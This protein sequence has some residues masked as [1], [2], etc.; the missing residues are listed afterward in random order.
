MLL[1]ELLVGALPFDCKMLRQAGYAEIQRLIREAEPLKPSTRLS[2][3][4]KAAEEAARQRQSDVRR[5][6][7]LLRGDLETIVMKALEKDRARRYASA[8]E[9]AADIGRHLAH[10]P[11]TARPPALAYQVGRFLKRQRSALYWCGA[12]ILLAALTAL[13]F[14]WRTPE[15]MPQILAATQLTGDGAQKYGLVADASRLYFTE[16]IRKIVQVPVTGG[17]VA[18]VTSLPNP[19]PVAITPDSSALLVAAGT[20]GPSSACFLCFQ[21]WLVPVSSGEPHKLANL[22]SNDGTFFPDGR[23]ILYGSTQGIALANRD[24]ENSRLLVRVDGPVRSPRVSPDQRRIRFFQWETHTDSI[25]LWESDVAGRHLHRL[26]TDWPGLSNMGHSSGSGNWTADGRYFVFGA[27]HDGRVDLWA[28]PEKTGFF[29]RRHSEPIRLTNGPMSYTASLPSS[30]GTKIFALATVGR[31]ELVR[32]D[33]SA[34]EFVPFLSGVSADEIVF[35]RDG[36]WAVYTTYPD[37]SLWRSRLDGSERLRLTYPPLE[38][39]RPQVSPEGSHV[40]FYS[41]KP[42]ADVYVVGMQGGT[43]HLVQR[44]AFSPV[45]SP[46]GNR[47]AVAAP[48]K[49][50]FATRVL[51]LKTGSVTAVSD[52]QLKMPVNWSPGNRLV[53]VNLAHTKVLA[54]DFQTQKWSPL[55]SVDISERNM[56]DGAASVDGRYVYIETN[57]KPSPKVIRI[58]VSD[59]HIEPVMQIGKIR[60]VVDPSQGTTLGV[61]PDGSVLV[62]HDV[63]RSRGVFLESEVAVITAHGRPLDCFD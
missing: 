6:V 42:T 41:V 38:A 58:R 7:R 28:L 31:G 19:L 54:F 10:E 22:E 55:L 9:F 57:E 26:L 32:F 59:G 46:D 14:W 39:Y 18:L 24:G 16:D 33:S 52:G 4:G 62:T 35:S 29:D 27:E 30:D 53:A 21:L 40:A 50:Q 2:G 44:D 37:H 12:S 43:P 1:Y 48:A 36:K 11:I 20:P 47:L 25:T 61:A 49:I 56:F 15:S 17:E 5:L 60:R 51:D 45:W 34:R 8:S 23:H 13:L 3:L 63:G